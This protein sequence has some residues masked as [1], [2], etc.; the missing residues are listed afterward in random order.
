MNEFNKL[1]DTKAE[2]E[3]DNYYKN[4]KALSNI[5]KQIVIARNEKGLT[6]RELAEKCG[7]KQSAL[8]RI[9]CLQVV[10]RIDTFI[11][12]ASALNLE[13]SVSSVTELKITVKI[14]VKHEVHFSES[15]KTSMKY[16][17]R[18]KLQL[19]SA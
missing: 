18:P 19:L 7:I 11:K 14:V 3:K 13:L 8:A 6:Q 12:I 16:Q 1:L 9:E 15:A 5:V 2:H 4:A 17:T 10:P